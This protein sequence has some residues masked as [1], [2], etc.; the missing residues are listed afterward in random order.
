MTSKTHNHICGDCDRKVK[1]WFNYCADPEGP[2]GYICDNC[3][4]KILEEILNDPNRP[5]IIN[6]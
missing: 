3:T 4:S 1:C 2:R 5:R 6:D